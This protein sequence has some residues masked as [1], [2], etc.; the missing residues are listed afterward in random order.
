M[1]DKS[2]MELVLERI[3]HALKS[4]QTKLDLSGLG[5][6]EIPPEIGRLSHLK[7]LSLENN[8]LKA[9]SDEIFQIEDLEILDLS[10]NPGLYALPPDIKS[11]TKLISLDLSN[12]YSL[13]ALPQEIGELYTLK[14]L[15]VQQSALY[16]LPRKIGQLKALIELQ[17]SNSHLDYILPEIGNLSNLVSLNLSANN[18]RNLPSTISNLSC[19]DQIDLSNNRFVSIPESIMALTGVRFLKLTGNSIKSIP[20]EILES[21]TDVDTLSSYLD[22]GELRKVQGKR[23]DRKEFDKTQDNLSIPNKEYERSVFISYKWEGESER[24]VNQLED[25][26]AK[27]NIR[28]VRDKKDLGY[29]ESIEKFEERIGQGRCVILVISDGYLRSE[30]CMYELLCIDENKNL[31]ERVLPLVL[32]SAYIYKPIDRINYIKYW[33]N[34]KNELDGAIRDIENLEYTRQHIATLEKYARIYSNCDRLLDT[35]ADMNAQSV[36]EHRQDNFSEIIKTIM[37]ML[38]FA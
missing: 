23:L 16:S 14:M 34:E 38:G 17:I 10:N 4:G 24:L 25:I 27:S 30:H 35:L 19:L 29:R 2:P 21:T 9:L 28:V 36:A 32:E 13:Y 31:R 37:V 15:K 12:C 26:L 11:F 7:E 22:V 3:N 18:L 8:L 5:L 33:G 1:N 6:Q 20:A